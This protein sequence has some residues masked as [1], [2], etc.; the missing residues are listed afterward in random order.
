MNDINSMVKNCPFCGGSA[1][2]KMGYSRLVPTAGYFIQC[3]R[4]EART[5]VM[6][7]GCGRLEC[8]DG[9]ITGRVHVEDDKDVIK[10]LIENW[11]RR[12]D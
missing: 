1:N 6:P 7:P 10:E 11:N 3:R 2:V 5:Y 8:I 12:T 9:R 4:C